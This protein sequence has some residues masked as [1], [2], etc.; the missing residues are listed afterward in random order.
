MSGIAE[1]KGKA[2]LSGMESATGEDSIDVDDYELPFSTV[3]DNETLDKPE[4]NDDKESQPKY[5]K[6]PTGAKTPDGKPLF[7][8]EALR[9]FGDIRKGELGGYIESEANLSHS[10]DCWVAM[11]AQVYDMAM[12]VD[13]AVITCCATVSGMGHVSG[14]ATVSG[15]A[16]V[17]GLAMVGDDAEV[18][19]HASV[20]G[21][22]S[23]SCQAI[24]TD[25]AIL[26]DRAA[27]TDRAKVCG[28][29]YISAGSVVDGDMIISGNDIEE[30]IKASEEAI[31]SFYD[32]KSQ[33]RNEASKLW[34]EA[35]R[36]AIAAWDEYEAGL[37]SAKDRNSII[38]DLFKWNDASS[39]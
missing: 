8:V 36:E 13:D 20:S 1:V 15:S 34:S 7:M 22:A 25:G 16:R 32:E 39:K 19:G 30:Q 2:V 10:G 4:S 14:R 37:I 38:R 27:I 35:M 33:Q 31:Q 9:D 26:V 11:S 29:A 5:K 12:V 6:H 21:L 3:E 17:H 28:D 24:V 23:V 18:S